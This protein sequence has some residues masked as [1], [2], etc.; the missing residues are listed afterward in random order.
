MDRREVVECSDKRS[1]Q[2]R[3][4]VKRDEERGEGGRRKET[5]RRKGRDCEEQI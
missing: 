5:K 2:G 3:G 1:G 4:R